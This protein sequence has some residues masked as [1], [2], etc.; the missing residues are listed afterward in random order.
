VN[1]DLDL[2]T[3]LRSGRWLE[4]QEFPPLRYA[5]PGIIPEGTTLLVGPPKIG[6]SWFV[7]SCALATATGGIVLEHI[8]VAA[9]P[10][11]Y[12]A[13]EDGHRRM[14][15]R[16]RMLLGDKRIPNAFEYMVT[17]EPGRVVETIAAWLGRHPGADPLVILDTLGKVMPPALPGESAY[18][19]DYRIG[20]ALKRLT[21]D[22][23]GRSLLVNHH[24]R[25]AA[26]DDF[27]D[28]VSGTHGLAGAADTTVVLVRGRNEQEGLLKVTGRDIAEGEYAVTLVNGSLWRLDGASLAEAATTGAARRASVGLGDRSAD[29]IAF[30]A[31]RPDQTAT[32]KDVALKLGI[33]EKGASNTL[34]RLAS[35]GRIEKVHRGLYTVA[36]TRS[37]SG[38]SDEFP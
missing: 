21:D 7:L 35:R 19:R 29:I 14:Q 33:D 11:L 37:E 31:S 34:N 8:P 26:S 6:K 18:Q 22:E 23:S 5:I 24:D 36:C 20:S 30:L 25:K 2:L 10:T 15:S 9:R 16:C 1:D 28:S 4:A 32:P 38:E 3:H 17:I 12:L 27:I 13:L